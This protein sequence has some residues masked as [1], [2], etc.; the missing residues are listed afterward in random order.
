MNAGTSKCQTG[1]PTRLPISRSLLRVV[2]SA[3]Y[4][5]FGTKCKPMFLTALHFFS[6]DL[7]RLAELFPDLRIRK[8]PCDRDGYTHSKVGKDVKMMDVQPVTAKLSHR[9]HRV[10]FQRSNAEQLLNR[11]ALNFLV[12][13]VSREG[14]T[15]RR[16]SNLRGEY[17]L[18]DLENPDV[19][20]DL[21]LSWANDRHQKCVILIRGTKDPRE[22]GKRRKRR[23]G[24]VIQKSQD[25]S[26]SQ[27]PSVSVDS[28]LTSADEGRNS[29]HAPATRG[30]RS[31]CDLSNLKGP[32][33]SGPQYGS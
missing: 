27:A 29:D 16:R 32:E 28:S 11:L 19:S 17:F 31:G 14:L 5:H 30:D 18:L 20:Y 4:E 23:V 15:F 13:L 24:T 33:D 8:I 6:G 26:V 25:L 10:L 21:E 9:Q 3:Y 12:E 1:L 7:D 22:R 2:N